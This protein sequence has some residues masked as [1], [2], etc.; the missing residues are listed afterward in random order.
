MH[1]EGFL[2]KILA[3]VIHKARVKVVS[4]VVTAAITTKKLTLTALGRA[5]E[6]PIQE[7]SGIQ[8]VNRL[9]GNRSLLIDYP[10]I[11]KAIS[12][13]LIGNKKHPEIIVDWTKYPNSEDAVIRA[14]LAVE[15]RAL[16]LYEERHSIKKMGNK[17][18]QKNFLKSLKQVIPASCIPIIV[19]DAGFHND[20][21]KEVLK[22]GW[23]YVGR[24]RGI[25]K[26]SKPE[27]KKFIFCSNLFKQATKKIRSLGKLILTKK[28]PTESYFYLVKGTLKGRKALTKQGKVRQ[29]KDSK[30][31][32]RSH[33]EPWLLAS[34]L[35]GRNAAKKV[36]CIYSRRMTIEEAF[37]DLKSLRYGL[38]L[39]EGKTKIKQRRDN[40]L[41]IAML[42]SLIAWITGLAGERM[43]LQ[44]QFQSNSIKNRRVISL[45]YLGCQLIRKKIPILLS[46]IW[47]AI[48]SCS[49]ETIYV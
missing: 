33:R 47:D 26:Y 22:L 45:P 41:L 31:Y 30:A 48:A 28:N 23:D 40:L 34:S 49:K 16:T 38:G 46:S 18:I 13:L 35:K 19:T 8:K 32:S 25:R 29:D 44:Y 39:D 43:K 3:P 4:E 5:I 10:Y 9:L 14:A 20:W 6:S 36:E 2:H 17:R 1:V 21:F 37:R 11:A 7:R 27:S 24:I 42:A 15:G 12:N